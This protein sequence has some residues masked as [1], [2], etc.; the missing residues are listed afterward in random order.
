MS[1]TFSLVMLNWRGL[2]IKSCRSIFKKVKTGLGILRRIRD[3]VPYIDS[4][5]KVFTSIIQSHFDYSV[6]QYNCNKGLRDKLQKLQNPAA[7]I[8]IHVNVVCWVG[9]VEMQIEI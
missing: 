7:G 3:L 5:N 9:R 4:L 1:Q 6:L 8:I 2:I